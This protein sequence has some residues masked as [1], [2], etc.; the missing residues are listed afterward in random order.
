MHHAD[1]ARPYTLQEQSL[2]KQGDAVQV[3]ARKRFP[4]G[5]LITAPYWDFKLAQA[6]TQTALN[7]KPPY[8]YEAFFFKNNLMARVDILHL[9]EESLWDIIEVKSSMSL[10]EDHIWDVAIQKYIMEQFSY[11]IDR[12][13][14]FHL[15][16]SCVY[17]DL[18][19]LFVKKEITEEVND[20]QIKVSEKVEEFKQAL[21]KKEPPEVD[22]GLHCNKPYEC[23]FKS[24]CWKKVP[25]PSVLDMPEMGALAWEYY[26]QNKI[27]LEDILEEELL[28]RQKIYKKVHTCNEPYIDK[29]SIRKELSLWKQPLYYLDFETIA[30]A[31]PR[32]EGVSPFQHIPFQFSVVCISDKKGSNSKDIGFFQGQKVT[33]AHYLHK[34]ASDPRYELSKK[35][36][37]FMGGQGS[38]VAYYKQFESLR[39]K[40]LAKLFPDLS[41]PL[42]SIESRLVDPLPLLRNHVC[43]KEFGSS[44]SMKSVAPVLLGEKWNYS[45]LEVQDGLMAQNTF[46]KMIVL[47]PKDPKRDILR[48]NLISY[49]SQDTYCLAGIVEW[50]YKQIVGP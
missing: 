3:E 40:E 21:S 9:K 48:K 31:I 12:C 49:C 47:D 22:I 11:P 35:L 29:A 28:P 37:G 41:E 25:Q 23:R 5:V 34:D 27:K 42:L 6:Q 13:F 32:F 4:D 39:L 30:P 1:L 14:V 46:E 16:R 19:N 18:E 24:Q 15:N 44:W 7:Q 10:K 20:L 45:H 36:V 33:E 38:V 43:F 2:F 26:Q 17:P 50:L 8:I